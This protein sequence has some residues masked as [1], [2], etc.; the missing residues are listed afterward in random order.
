MEQNFTGCYMVKFDFMNGSPG[1]VG[2][3]F[4]IQADHLDS[5]IP[6]IR[7]IR[8]QEKQLEVIE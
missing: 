5:D 1:Y 8:N 7:L 6:V 2:D 3:L 4:I